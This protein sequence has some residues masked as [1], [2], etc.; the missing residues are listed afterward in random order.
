MWY[1]GE[2]TAAYSNGTVDHSGS[3]LAGVRGARPGIV[4]TAHP[5]VGDTHRQE[6]WPGQAEDQYW[7]VDLGQRYPCRSGTSGMRR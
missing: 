3:W 4:M 7:M 6:Y 2:Q 1:F 5:A